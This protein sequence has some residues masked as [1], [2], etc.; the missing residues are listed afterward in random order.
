MTIRKCDDSVK[1]GQG[2]DGSLGQD[3]SRRYRTDPWNSN[4]KGNY[5]SKQGA[6]AY[7]DR[8]ASFLRNRLPDEASARSRDIWDDVEGQ[9]SDSTNRAVRSRGQP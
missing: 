5:L 2:I 9:S 1:D 3:Y 4:R 8:D 6:G 7:Q